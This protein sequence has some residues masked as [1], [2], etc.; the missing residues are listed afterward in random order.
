MRPDDAQSWDT[1]PAGPLD[2]SAVEAVNARRDRTQAVRLAFVRCD[3][4][5]GESFPLLVQSPVLAARLQ[6]SLA[7]VTR[8]EGR[9]ELHPPRRSQTPEARSRKAAAILKR[10]GHRLA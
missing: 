1:N 8:L 5:S 2:A 7:K 10:V 3:L 6:P 9:R 4:Q